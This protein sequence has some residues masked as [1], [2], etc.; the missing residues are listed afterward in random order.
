MNPRILNILETAMALVVTSWNI[1]VKAIVWLLDKVAAVFKLALVSV[2]IYCVW[3][4]I[5]KHPSWE[6]YILTA[7]VIYGTVSFVCIIAVAI[8]ENRRPGT[9]RRILKEIGSDT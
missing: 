5:R 8:L 2:A 4:I 7:I 3:D 1:P 6:G 9:L